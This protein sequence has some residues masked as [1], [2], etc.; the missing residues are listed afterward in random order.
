MDET[1]VIGDLS[2][3][4]PNDICYKN[5]AGNTGKPMLSEALLVSGARP[6]YSKL[7]LKNESLDSN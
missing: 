1:A 7:S 3:Y 2:G 4:I 5:F 6:F